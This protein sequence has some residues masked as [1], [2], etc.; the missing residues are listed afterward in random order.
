MDN[1]R[2]RAVGYRRVSMREQVD[3]FSL[4]AQE[5]NIR[6]YAEDHDWVITGMYADAGIS[7]K[8]DSERELRRVLKN[9][10]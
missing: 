8:R 7:A 1:I 9:D 10:Y 6:K 5:N 2:L 3:G 4:D